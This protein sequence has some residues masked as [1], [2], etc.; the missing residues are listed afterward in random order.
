MSPDDLAADTAKYEALAQQYGVESEAPLPEG[1]PYDSQQHGVPQPQHQ[2]YGHHQQQHQPLPNM[3]DDPV[4]HFHG[5]MQQL[6][7]AAG[8]FYN[9]TMRGEIVRALEAS[10]KTANF[11][12]HND[13]ND[14]VLHLEREHIRRLERQLP[15]GRQTDLL[16]HSYGLPNAQALRA[17]V[18]NRDRAMVVDWAAKN[19][20]D[21][22]GVYYDLAIAQYGYRPKIAYTR[23]QMSKLMDAADKGG[24]EFEKEWAKYAKAERRAEQMRRR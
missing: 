19:G 2:D 24:P 13:Y 1:E 21:P 7:G 18:L 15:D 8:Q 4:G 10:E 16:A 17:A 23:S 6:E 20:Q 12:T 5:R 22:A 14:A 9:H 11:E 3:L